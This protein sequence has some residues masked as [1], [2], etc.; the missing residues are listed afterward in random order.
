MEQI[1]NKPVSKSYVI[2]YNYNINSLYK[3]KYIWSVKYLE[4]IEED[5]F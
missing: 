2:L 4:L 5:F 1:I 3:S